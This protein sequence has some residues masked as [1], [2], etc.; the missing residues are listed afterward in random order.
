MITPITYVVHVTGKFTNDGNNRNDD[1][2]TKL[3]CDIE[4]FH[5]RNT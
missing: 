4:I 1:M 3:Y 2:E 5:F